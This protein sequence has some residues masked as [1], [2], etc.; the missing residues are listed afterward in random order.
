MTAKDLGH[1]TSHSDVAPGAELRPGLWSRRSPSGPP[2][3]QPTRSGTAAT[4]ASRVSFIGTRIV[5]KV[6]EPAL[7]GEG[8]AGAV[9]ELWR[10]GAV[11]A[12]LES[13][14]AGSAQWRAAARGPGLA[15][16]AGHGARHQGAVVWFFL[17]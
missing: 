5:A 10:A 9:R 1:R 16:M 2:S 8:A 3:A 13:L 12:L 15:A 17:R 11:A 4:A 7:E 6:G 14:L